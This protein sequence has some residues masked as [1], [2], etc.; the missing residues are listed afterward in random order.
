MRKYPLD[1]MIP[2][3]LCGHFGRLEGDVHLDDTA[4]SED[5]RSR[6]RLKRVRIVL[7]VVGSI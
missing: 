7:R 6:K 5:E 1:V 4:R 3:S 2:V